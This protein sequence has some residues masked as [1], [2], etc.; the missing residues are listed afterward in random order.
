MG[1]VVW[2]ACWIGFGVEPFPYGLLT[3]I[4]SL[5]AIILSS[6]IL[7]A[8]KFESDRD[9]M[10]SIRNIKITKETYDLLSHM[11]EDITDLRNKMLNKDDD[12]D[13]EI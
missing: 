7:L 1:H 12:G 6:L 8:T 10:L 2:F 11:H 9:N 3:M 5:E 13:D 4:V